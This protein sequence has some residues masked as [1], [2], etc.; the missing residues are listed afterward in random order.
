MT[1]KKSQILTTRNI[2]FRANVTPEIKEMGR[3]MRAEEKTFDLF[4]ARNLSLIARC[5]G[6]WRG[7]TLRHCQSEVVKVVDQMD[8]TYFCKRKSNLLK[9]WSTLSLGMSSRKKILE[10]KDE[11]MEKARKNLAI[12]LMKNNEEKGLL[13]TNEMV[14]SEMHRIM[15]GEMNGW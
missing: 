3:R 5:L 1:A 14:V 2:Y 10:R 4:S 7:I 9:V 6:A 13:I 15:Y 11:A 12:H 8:T